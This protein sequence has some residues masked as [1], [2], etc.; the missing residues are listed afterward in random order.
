LRYTDFMD[1]PPAEKKSK[2]EE[3]LLEWKSPSR[4]FKQRNREF[5][6]NVVAIVFLLFVIM[7]FAQE[8][9]L[10]L[11][12]L[13][14]VFFIYVTSTVP[15]EEI[16]NRITNFGLENANHFYRWEQLADF[17]FEERWGQTIMTLRPYVG[18]YIIVLVPLE[19]K[20]K[21]KELVSNEIPYRDKPQKNWVDNA[22]SWLTEKVPLEKPQT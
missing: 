18:S 22:A 1:E 9:M 10:I 3:T 12:V 21:V 2:I 20:S 7:V 5:Y 8:F 17:W 19:L 16:R 14:I 15:P 13:A 6:T 4:P 11:A